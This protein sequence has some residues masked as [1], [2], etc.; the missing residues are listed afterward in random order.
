[1]ATVNGRVTSTNGTSWSTSGA[2]PGHV[3]V[4]LDFKYQ[5][6]SVNL[7]GKLD[8]ANVGLMGH[9]RGGQGVLA[10]YNLYRNSS[11][12]SRG[13]PSPPN[14]P[15]INWASKIPG[16]N[17]KGIFEIGPT[18]VSLPTS[19]DGTG[20]QY[21]NADG[22]AWNVL[23]PMCD[24]DVYMLDGVRVFDRTLAFTGPS[25]IPADTPATQ[26]STYTVWGTNHH[27]YNT[28]WQ[29]DDPFGRGCAGAGNV[30]LFPYPA[31]DGSGSANQRTTGLA[32]VLAFFR[33]NV[34]ASATLSFN[35]NFDPRYQLPGAIT[36][37]PARVDEG[38][39][40]SPN[41]SRTKVLFEFLAS[42]WPPGTSTATSSSAVSLVTGLGVPN[43][44]PSL[45][46]GSVTWNSSSCSTYLQINWK[47]KDTGDNIAG[48]QTLDFRVSR[49]LDFYK[50]ASASTSFQIQL[51]AKD[52]SDA[53]APTGSAVSL[54]RYISL[55]G[56]VG[57]PDVV[58]PADG[59]H[60][61]LQTIR[62]PLTD[63]MGA[64]L[65]QIRGVRLIFSDTATGAIYVA[66]LRLSN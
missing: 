25:P 14:T 23:L 21:L 26:K 66:S 54:N 39:T 62:I 42:G 50:N 61:I 22:I 51:I 11:I 55:A 37:I 57:I 64:N 47:D 41:L 15:N 12:D 38:F 19:S 28:E 2:V 59:I 16:L 43:H 33:A 36:S 53:G 52:G 8:F 32:S 58:M 34:G 4:P 10:A 24:G 9:S 60:P 30:A 5:V 46:A 13:I 35:Q 29:Q 20:S 3:Y 6:L 7:T 49:Q 65:S 63:F 1:L 27:F 44:D 17:I 31:T 56:P 48:Y 45:S 40:P 18:D